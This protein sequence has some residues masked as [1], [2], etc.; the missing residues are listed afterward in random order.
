MT[1]FGNL[2]SSCMIGG[3][4]STATVLSSDVQFNVSELSW[5]VSILGVMRFFGGS[6]SKYRNALYSPFGTIVG[7]EYPLIQ[8]Q[9][10]LIKS[11]K[12]GLSDI[13]QTIFL[14]SSEN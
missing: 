2:K 12:F 14:N 11:K 7:R 6:D 10:Y 4:V 5:Y 9:R 8:K 1:V 13:E 3:N